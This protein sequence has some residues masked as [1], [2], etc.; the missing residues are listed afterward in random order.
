MNFP[1]VKNVFGDGQKKGS[2]E[3]DGDKKR[4]RKKS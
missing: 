2:D 4:F 1:V 3:E